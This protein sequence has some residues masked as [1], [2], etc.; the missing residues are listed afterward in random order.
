MILIYFLCI[1]VCAK[2]VNERKFNLDVAELTWINI[3]Q[4]YLDGLRVENIE[5]KS[6]IFIGLTIQK[7][8]LNDVQ[9][10]IFYNAICNEIETGCDEIQIICHTAIIDFATLYLQEILLLAKDK[11]LLN[12]GELYYIQMYT[13]N[14]LM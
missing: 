14:K 12:I 7:A 13:V 3:L 11:L 9:R 8:Y 1:H 5:L 2:Y 10:T 6:K 4:I